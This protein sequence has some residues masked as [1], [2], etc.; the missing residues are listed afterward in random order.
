MLSFLQ[1]IER[2]GELRTVPGWNAHRLRQT[3]RRMRVAE[4]DC[5]P[6]LDGS[7]TAIGIGYT[8]RSTHAQNLEAQQIGLLRIRRCR[9]LELRGPR[10]G[11]NQSRPAS[12]QHSPPSSKATR[13]P[14]R[15]WTVWP[16]SFRMRATLPRILSRNA[17]AWPRCSGCS[18]ITSARILHW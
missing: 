12:A 14:C 7:T 8:G 9:G 13:W 1:E 18:A 17:S 11:R 16:A 4:F 2:E 3:E 10:V 15:S 5:G 6:F